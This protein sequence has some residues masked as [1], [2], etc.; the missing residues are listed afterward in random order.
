MPHNAT[1]ANN[2]A[3]HLTWLLQSKPFIPTPPVYDLIPTER[4]T[5]VVAATGSSDT[6]LPNGQYHAS[7]VSGN[8]IFAAEQ[9]RGAQEGG[10]VV[11]RIVRSPAE[12]SRVNTVASAL[13]MARP[14]SKSTAALSAQAK[15]PLSVSSTEQLPDVLSLDLT[16][17]E[18]PRRNKIAGRKRKS[19]E[20][21][22]D[23]TTKISKRKDPP[24][25]DD[26]GFAC[27]D[28]FPDDPPPPYATMASQA[29]STTV[30]L[31]IRS[32]SPQKSFRKFV[33]IHQP[34]ETQSA[35]GE[36]LADA[37]L[38]HS[39]SR[40]RR[41]LSRTNSEIQQQ[42]R[43]S[44]RR[45][46]P[47]SGDEVECEFSPEPDSKISATK[48]NAS[49]TSSKTQIQIPSQ[50]EFAVVELFLNWSSQD[51]ERCF[52]SI[53]KQKQFVDEQISMIIKYG[54]VP[55]PEV[56][57]KQK[58]TNEKVEAMHLLKSARASILLLRKRKDDLIRLFA[59][60]F[61]ADPHALHS[62]NLVVS[63]SIHTDVFNIIHSLRATGL[64]EQGFNLRKPVQ[65]TI[66]RHDQVMVKGT[67]G[68]SNDTKSRPSMSTE[69]IGINSSDKIKQTQQPPESMLSAF[70]KP[71]TWDASKG[72]RFQSEPSENAVQ[73]RRKDQ[74]WKSR[75]QTKVSSDV[76]SMLKTAGNITTDHQFSDAEEEFELPNDYEDADHHNTHNMGGYGTAPQPPDDEALAYYDY[77]DDDLFHSFCDDMVNK[78]PEII[79]KS[80]PRPKPREV[81]KETSGNQLSKTTLK[82]NTYKD[83][84][85]VPE[86]NAA[87]LNFSWSKDVKKV[88]A[89][90]FHLRG[91]RLNQL[92]AINATLAGHDT[93]V[94]M[95]TGGGKSLCY[96]LPALVDSGKTTG[97]TIVISPLLSLMEDQVNHLRA[98]NVQAFLLNGETDSQSKSH[99]MRGL[100]EEKPEKFIR[101]LYVTPEMLT[102]NQRMRDEFDDLHRRR[103][104]ARIVIDE[105]HCVSQWGHDFRPDYT[106]LGWLRDQFPGVPVLALTATATENVK[107]DVIHQL[108][109]KTPELFK[110]SFNRPNLYYELRPKHPKVVN[111]IAEII[112]TMYDGQSGIVYCFSR[113]DCEKVAGE[114]E[115]VH[116]I[117]SH[118]YHAQLDPYMK[119]EVQAD[120]QSGRYQVIVA[121]IAFGM[122]ID[123]ADVRFVIHHSAP[124]SLEGYYQETGRAGRD[125]ERSGC[126][127]FYSYGDIRKMENMINKQ[128]DG[129]E[130][131]PAQRRRQTEMLKTVTRFCQNNADCRRK[132]V[133]QYFGEAFDPKDCGGACDICSSEHSFHT[134]DLSS[135]AKAAVDLVFAIYAKL[136]VDPGKVREGFRK[137]AVTFNELVAIFNGKAPKALERAECK[138]LKQFNAG[139]DLE[140]PVIERV[141]AKLMAENA[142]VEKNIPGS[143]KTKFTLHYIVVS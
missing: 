72:I 26:D 91:F 6:Q 83:A 62:E 123:K 90:V 19:G 110:Q 105:A 40:K 9:Q 138:T 131:D 126:Y 54:G 32:P 99:L 125:G 134:V 52:Q 130:M 80:L 122:G 27:I 21:S 117:P 141:F 4:P 22:G 63:A 20:I 10:E 107:V 55:G 104:L 50:Q 3:E 65:D 79:S 76:P 135:Y 31:P 28:D 58:A 140:L 108:H 96:Q 139:A 46:V 142:L 29:E 92:E 77:E 11:D 101:L 111:E 39:N 87:L 38:L 7:E 75:S 106:Q 24:P 82:Q 69:F 37:Q 42:N 88:L 94:L 51:W 33:D 113:K 53:S 102:K 118:H 120:W 67:Q 85:D 56:A 45:I 136:G 119:R 66:E 109:M 12:P 100:R 30:S 86:D 97:V 137:K 127:L 81:F 129:R 25:V 49:C 61:S 57:A 124:K 44:K 71:Q 98:L 68:S 60:P 47:D 1:C 121:T 8:S 143:G 18:S 16:R 17:E 43:E 14:L 13:S 5:L 64:L 116:N 70:A 15:A 128:H 48:L 2:L 89:R 132:Q 73:L 112:K 23:D 115:N 74:S 93:F 34:P 36:S 59:D 103:K 114:L 84:W 35:S 95:P 133:L 78:P 41:S